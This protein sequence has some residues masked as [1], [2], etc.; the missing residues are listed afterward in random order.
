MVCVVT[1]GFSF[2]VIASSL[3]FIS[4]IQ[5]NSVAVLR[6]ILMMCISGTAFTTK[7]CVCVCVR[8]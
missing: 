6:N 3:Q 4:I 7:K 8:A 2:D 1:V 5:S